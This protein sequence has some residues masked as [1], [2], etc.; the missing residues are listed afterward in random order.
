MAF[1]G[2]LLLGYLLIRRKLTFKMPL[3]VWISFMILALFSIYLTNILE[4]WGL[5][6]LSSAKVCFIYSL[7]PFITALLSYIHFKEKMT[8][9]KWVG[10]CIGFLGFIPV[11]LAKSSLE[12]VVMA[13]GVFSWA[14][15]AVA[16]AAFFAVYGW[17]I[18][19]LVV[20]DYEV[21]PIKANGWSMLMGG[22]LALFT[23]LFV[24]NY[25]PIPVAAGAMTP[26]L[27]GVLAMTII[28]NVICFNLYGY[29]L[30]KY[31]ATLLSFFGLLSP[32]FA[33]LN[34]WLIIGEPISLTIFL[35]TAIVGFGLW[36]FYRAELKQGY[37]QKDSEV[38]ND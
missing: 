13:F 12:D 35:S 11:I 23:S 10:M 34:A 14:E 17:V 19:R 30:R 22:F 8:P 31:T 7:S 6:Y 24:D 27:K 18:L 4:F 32:I 28:S 26:F 33:S 1:A 16:G 36:I 25:S 20:K 29:L 9:A 15:L 5:Q 37:V 21:S 3:R 38:V 2:V